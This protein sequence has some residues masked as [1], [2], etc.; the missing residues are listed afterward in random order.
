MELDERLVEAYNNISEAGY[1]CDEEEHEK[2]KQELLQLEIDDAEQLYI[3]AQH[4]MHGLGE[5][6]IAKALLLK[7]QHDNAFYGQSCIVLSDIERYGYENY[8]GAFKVLDEAIANG[9]AKDNV[10]FAKA[11]IYVDIE[12]YQSALDCLD[13]I[14]ATKI[15]NYAN[16]LNWYL[17]V[18]TRMENTD[19]VK[20]KFDL[21]EQHY[22]EDVSYP[23]VIIRYAKF[24]KEQQQYSEALAV[25]AKMPPLV[26]EYLEALDEYAAIYRLLEDEQ[27]AGKYQKW[28]HVLEKIGQLMVK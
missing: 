25:L 9:A 6:D 14:D 4:F 8:E 20:E 21:A 16:V 5:Y 24:L 15:E 3:I 10:L 7:I 12:E 19:L 27:Q 17:V 28:K 18:Y 26:L 13:E 22:S 1:N 23:S 11:R 2:Y